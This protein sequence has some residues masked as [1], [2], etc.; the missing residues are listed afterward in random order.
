MQSFEEAVAQKWPNRLGILR[1]GESERNV[2]KE[3]AK[4]AGS[5]GIFGS[6]LR[7]VDTPLTSKGRQQAQATGEYLSRGYQFDVVFTSPY[8]RTLET[9]AGIQSLLQPT[10]PQ[11]IEERI[12]EI[13]FGILDGLTADGIKKQHPEEHSRRQREGKYW[14]RP[15]GGESRP[16]VALESI[17]F[18][19]PSL[20]TTERRAFLSSVTAS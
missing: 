18:S 1:H 16:D 10:P 14:Y 7:D 19:V 12:R 15:P 5:H 8:K 3:R 20:A 13:E 2:A 9:A 6:G 17:V 11:V 4:L